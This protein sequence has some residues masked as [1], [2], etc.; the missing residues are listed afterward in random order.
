MDSA[1]SGPSYLVASVCFILTLQFLSSPKFARQGVLIGVFG[2]AVAVIGTLLKPEIVT[3][4]WIIPGMVVGSLVGAA[5]SAWIPMTK[6]PERI[7]LSHAFGGLAAA[8]VGIS[9]YIRHDPY[10]LSQVTLTA[11]GLETFFGF[12]TFTGSLIAFGKLQGFISGRPITFPGLNALNI[13][14][15]LG[16]LVGLVV[17]V[18]NPEMANVLYGICGAGL[19]I[20]ITAVLPIGGADMPVV[21]SLLNSYAGLSSSATGFAIHNNVLIIAGALDG[22]SGFILSMMMS[23]AMN[24]SFANV[25]FG[26]FGTGGG[27]AAVAADGRVAQYNQGTVEDASN[28]LEAAQSVIV[29]PGYGLA[30][31][32]AQ[33]AVRELGQML[34]KRG[35]KVSYAIHPVAGRMP[36]HMN[37]LLAEADVPY[38][39]LYDIEDIN[40]DFAQTDVVLVVGANDVVNPAAKTNKGSP[41]YGMPVFN[42]ELAKTVIVLKRSMNTGFS[43]LDNELF[44]FPNTMVVLGDAKK[45]LQGFKGELEQRD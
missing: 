33:H 17:F 32:Q 21:I 24:R 28:A 18:V 35:A 9:E 37:V 26:A 4:K 29:V 25:L 31:S 15:F 43:G 23:K 44:Y 6:M 19:V 38:D 5:M 10:H 3:F 11:L 42:V 14:A 7:A 30:V 45:T 13:A 1:F 36:G 8:L 2:M 12:L 16:S 27:T 22:T 34:E 20:G 39:Q 40:D 41:I